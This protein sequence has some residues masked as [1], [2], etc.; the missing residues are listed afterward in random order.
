[1]RKWS[2]VAALVV[3]YVLG[4]RAGKERYEQIRRVATKAWGSPPVQAAVDRAE[5]VAPRMPDKVSDAAG[6]VVGKVKGTTH[7]ADDAAVSRDS[8]PSGAVPLLLA[9][10]L[11]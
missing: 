11:V 2:L 10:Y 1:M 6:Y 5:E 8:T 7:P 4:A 9:L 3:G